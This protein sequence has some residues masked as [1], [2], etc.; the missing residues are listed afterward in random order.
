L[1]GDV[2]KLKTRE[3]ISLHDTPRGCIPEGCALVN[4][5]HDSPAVQLKAASNNISQQG[6]AAGHRDRAP[7]QQAHKA[8]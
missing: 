4:P 5:T 3:I 1:C 8:A 2:S 7:E 6:T